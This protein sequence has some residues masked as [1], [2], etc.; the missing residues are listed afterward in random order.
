MNENGNPMVMPVAPYYGNVGDGMF[1]GNG[2]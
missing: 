2:A 1:G